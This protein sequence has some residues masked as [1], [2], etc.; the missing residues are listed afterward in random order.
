MADLGQGAAEAERGSGHANFGLAD[1]DEPCD[2]RA[3]RQRAGDADARVEPVCRKG[4][5]RG[6]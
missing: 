1:I 4:W 2:Q 6:A 5:D 3:A